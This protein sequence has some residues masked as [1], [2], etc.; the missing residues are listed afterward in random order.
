M[1]KCPSQNTFVRKNTSCTQ[2]PTTLSRKKRYSHLRKAA[3]ASL[4]LDA[5]MTGE[6]DWQ[7][8]RTAARQI[9]SFPASWYADARHR[10]MMALRD[11]CCAAARPRSLDG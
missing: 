6:S 8:R 10:L 5:S 9:F 1:P 2:K 4:L 7:L 11:I 3:D